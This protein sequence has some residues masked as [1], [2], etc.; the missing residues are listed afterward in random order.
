MEETYSATYCHNHP[1]VETSLRCNKCGEYICAKCAVLT[2]TGYSCK[3]CIKNQQKV[4][5]NSNPLDAVFAVAAAGVLSFLGSLL[6]GI[7]GYFTIFLAPL[8]GVVIGEAVRLVTGKRRSQQMFKM[9]LIA[10]IVGALPLSV[11]ALLGFLLNISVGAGGLWSILT[12]IYYG[13]YLVVAST[14]AYYRISGRSI[15]LRR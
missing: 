10:T 11:G 7:A 14:T 1:T 13:Y 4:Y 8:A 2:P 9:A 3:S 12:V 5:D 15:R 6:V